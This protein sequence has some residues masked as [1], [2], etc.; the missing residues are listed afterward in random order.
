MILAAATV[1]A[2]WP[3]GLGGVTGPLPRRRRRTRPH[4]VKPDRPTYRPSETGEARRSRSTRCWVTR[5]A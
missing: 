4:Q 2:G 1:A 3:W 5:S